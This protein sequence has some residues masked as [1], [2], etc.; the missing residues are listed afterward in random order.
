MMEVVVIRHKLSVSLKSYQ[1]TTY[2]GGW[3][4]SNIYGYE[5]A[6]DI[7]V[8]QNENFVLNTIKSDIIVESGDY[9]SDIR[10]NIY[11]DS[12]S[13][14]LQHYYIL[15]LHLLQI[16]FIYIINGECMMC[17]KLLLIYQI[18]TLY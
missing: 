18:L 5:S 16:K 6:A 4:I 2:W 1:D 13:L 7:I 10:L 17:I 14:G 3:S 12:L 11:N 9:L 15:K 8:N